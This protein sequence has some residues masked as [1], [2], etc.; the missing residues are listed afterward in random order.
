MRPGR[1]GFA[2]ALLVLLAGAARAEAQSA[3]RESGAPVA[4]RDLERGI[5]LTA[6]DIAYAPADGGAGGAAAAPIGW[7]TR[8]VVS[9]GEAL[10]EPTISRPDVVRSGESVQLVWSDGAVELR[11]RG[12]ALGAAAQGERISVRVDGRRRFEGIV[13]GPGLVRMESRGNSR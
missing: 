2:A 5:V 1:L 11:V 8:R 4:A 6:A 10:R 7:V 12:T 3:P 9:Q 13:V